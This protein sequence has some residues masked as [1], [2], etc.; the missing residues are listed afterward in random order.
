MLAIFTY[1]I[2]IDDLRDKYIHVKLPHHY[3]GHEYIQCC[4][5]FHALVI[6]ISSSS[7]GRR[8]STALKF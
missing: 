1:C 4:P 5:N 6:I 7:S 8:R 2:N 3:Q